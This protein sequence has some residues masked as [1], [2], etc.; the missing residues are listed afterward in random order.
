MT[1][2]ETSAFDQGRKDCRE[3]C[4]KQ[5]PYTQLSSLGKLWAA[6]YDMESQRARVKLSPPDD[7]Q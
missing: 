5:N 2:N 4:P 6:G 7:A 3:G 1:K